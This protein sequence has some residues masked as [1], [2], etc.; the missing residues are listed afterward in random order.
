MSEDKKDFEIVSGDGTLDISPVYD[1]LNAAK[2][3]CEH[4]VQNIVIP[5]TKK[6]REK[7]EEEEKK[8][9]ENTKKA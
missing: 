8:K 6:E 7:E 3:K 2:P 5:K 9:K 4:P 1:H